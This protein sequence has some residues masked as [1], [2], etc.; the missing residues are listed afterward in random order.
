MVGGNNG[1]IPEE[2]PGI[3]FLGIFR[4]GVNSQ[5]RLTN[6]HKQAALAGYTLSLA[7]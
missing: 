5:A 3:F 4:D 6:K 1:E 2:C 7:R